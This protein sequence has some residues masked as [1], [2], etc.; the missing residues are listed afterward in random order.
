[1]SRRPVRAEQIVLVA[2]SARSGT[3]WVA[4]LLNYDN[5]YRYLFEPFHPDQASFTRAWLPRQYVKPGET[6]PKFVG[7]ALQVL[8]G[9]VRDMWIEQFDQNPTSLN[10]LVKEIWANLLLGWL[11][12][13]VPSMKIVLVLRHPFSVVSSQL[14][15]PWGWRADTGNFLEQHALML[16][17]LEFF[18]KTLMEADCQFDRHL[19]TWCVEN[20]V[21]LRQLTRTDAHVVFYE[22]LLRR[23]ERELRSLFAYLERGWSEDVLEVVARPSALTGVRDREPGATTL[24]FWRQRLGEEHLARGL[25]LIE[26]FGLGHLYGTGPEPLCTNATALAPEPGPSLPTQMLTT[27]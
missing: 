7:P 22:H 9:E 4:E 15:N 10:R 21:P 13:L 5:S 24:T 23:P 12:A 11:C 1:M 14:T 27:R 17:H 25:R 20:L 6:D 2:G 18:Q 19:L 3:T 8:L 16:D 26:T